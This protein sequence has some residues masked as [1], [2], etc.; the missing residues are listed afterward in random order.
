M[1][2]VCSMDGR[3]CN[4]LIKDNIDQPRGLA[5]YPA[6]GNFKSLF[7]VSLGKVRLGLKVIGHRQ[8]A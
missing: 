2:G 6:E 7:C 1:V 5:L 8:C 3:N 4:Q